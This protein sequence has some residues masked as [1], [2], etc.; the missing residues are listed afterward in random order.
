LLVGAAPLAARRHLGKD[1][2]GYPEA[3]AVAELAL[4]LAQATVLRHPA[5]AVRSA[6]SVGGGVISVAG[7]DTA[8]TVVTGQ[9]PNVIPSLRI[10][11]RLP[12]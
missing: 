10:W 2:L 4:A 7:A 11:T 12:T 8:R 9:N 5:L 1:L 3:S 6:Y